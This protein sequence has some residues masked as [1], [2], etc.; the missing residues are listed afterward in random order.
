MDLFFIDNLLKMCDL[1]E[2]TNMFPDNKKKIFKSNNISHICS[3]SATRIEIV[4]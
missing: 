1:D 2:N 3:Q 4:C